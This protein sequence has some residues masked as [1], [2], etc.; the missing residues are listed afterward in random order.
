[1]IPS[2]STGS[3]DSRRVDGAYAQRL[4]E[5]GGT[6]RPE[7]I[8]GPR[9]MLPCWRSSAAVT[10]PSPR[11]PFRTGRT[12]RADFQ[13]LRDRSVPR[14]PGSGRAG[15]VHCTREESPI[16]AL[17]RIIS[18]CAIRRVL[19]SAGPHHIRA[20]AEA[21]GRTPPASG[22]RPTVQ[23]TPSSAPPQPASTTSPR[24]P[25]AVIG[26]R[27]MPP[28]YSA[29]GLLRARADP[30]TGPR[31][32]REHDLA[33]TYDVVASAGRARLATPYLAKPMVFRGWPCRPV[34]SRGRRRRVG[35]EHGHRAIKKRSTT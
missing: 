19:R 29:L 16:H 22:T 28:R 11:S 23:A 26:T 2:P 6:S 35:P 5:A 31:A 17:G 9:T 15:P 21:L 1:M 10:S 13:S 32:W 4:A 25:R 18:G 7:C 14:G 20:M 34:L 33:P 8:R 12:P 30:S 27:R 24:Q 3:A